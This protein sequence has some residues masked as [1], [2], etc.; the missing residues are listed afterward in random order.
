MFSFNRQLAGS[1]VQ[2]TT[3]S[4]MNFI[5]K[6]A[7]RNMEYLLDKSVWCRSDVYSVH[8]ME[9]LLQQYRETLGK[10]S[11]RRLPCFKNAHVEPIHIQ[12]L[13]NRFS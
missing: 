5:L 4:M 1:A 12:M 8:T 10:V 3:V 9:D 7:N 11:S 13:N 2:L 6:K